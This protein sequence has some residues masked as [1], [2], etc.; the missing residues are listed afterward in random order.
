MELLDRHPDLE[1]ASGAMPGTYSIKIDP[2][3]KPVVHGPLRKPAAILPK[4]V[5]K[6]RE[7]KR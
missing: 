3:G 4:I 5:D 1:N 6:L 7:W 2:T